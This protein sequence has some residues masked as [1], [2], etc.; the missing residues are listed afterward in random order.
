MG[1]FSKLKLVLIGIIVPLVAGCSNGAYR[2]FETVGYDHWGVQGRFETRDMVFQNVTQ[3]NLVTLLSGKTFVG[4]EESDG[5]GGAYGALTVS[6]YAADG[7]LLVCRV[8]YKVGKPLD[9]AATKRWIS[10][11]TDNH[12][13][14]YR[15]TE[16][17]F[18]EVNGS[19][20]YGIIQ[21]DASFGRLAFLGYDRSVFRD[22]RKGHLQND[23]PAAVYT[24][25][26]EFPAAESLGTVVNNNQTSWNYF[27]LVEQDAGDRVIRPDLVT[28]FTPVPLKPAVAP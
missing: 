28:A 23:V 21:Y 9:G 3:E 22:Y 26:P 5:R 7:S 25:C 4:Y 27:E 8:S 2:S 6:H 18:I 16:L 14:G 11:S 20:T 13:I 10:R 17:E 24:A 15:V 1:V 12:N 19:S